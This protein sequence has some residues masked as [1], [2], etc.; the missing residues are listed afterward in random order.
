[1][2]LEGQKVVVVGGSS[3]IGRGAAAALLD[4]GADVVLVARSRR[5]LEDARV[6][7]GD[8]PRVSCVTADARNEDQVREALAQVGS[9]DHLV[10]TMGI[11]PPSAPIGSFDL[12]AARTLVDT[13]LLG[14]ITLA[15]HAQPYLRVGGSITFTSGISGDRPSIPG[16]SVVSAVA[17]SL[18][19]FA[20]DGHG[21]VDPMLIEEVDRL[22]P[23]GV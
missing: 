2:A 13:V 23:E 4:R 22:D 19:Y 9:F 21:R 14:A 15:K 7:L 16:G 10:V 11:A 3:G 1:M 18:G 6:A 20:R 8:G 12:D 17:G 5:K